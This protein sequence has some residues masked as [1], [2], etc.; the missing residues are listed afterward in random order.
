MKKTIAMHQ[1]RDKKQKVDD[2]APQTA[3]LAYLL[4]REQVS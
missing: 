3:V 1:Q 4:E 2:G